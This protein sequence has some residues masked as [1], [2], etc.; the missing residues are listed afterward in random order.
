MVTLTFA[1]DQPTWLY[2]G[3]FRLWVSTTPRLPCCT[4]LVPPVVDPSGG[5]PS[6]THSCI[7][8]AVTYV[9]L[10][11]V[12]VAEA[13][14]QPD[15]AFVYLTGKVVTYAGQDFLY[16]EE[17]DRSC[18]I[19]I[20]KIGHWPGGW[21]ES[22]SE[23]DAPHLRRT[24]ALDHGQLTSPEWDRRRC[25]TA[26]GEQTESEEATGSTTLLPALVSSAWRTG[27]GSTISGCS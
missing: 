11:P 26:D 16:V 13:K 5:P 18:G 15:G 27:S 24:R 4:A 8:L 22:R 25:P 9:T 6:I 12:S 7:A 19:R 21:Y 3:S 20:D 1:K 23:R 14:Q 2:L 17:D 10:P